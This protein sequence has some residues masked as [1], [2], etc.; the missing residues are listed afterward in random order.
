MR[1]ELMELMFEFST[2]DFNIMWNYQLPQK[3]KLMR[4]GKLNNLIITLT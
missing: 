4:R 2:F 3:L 1:S